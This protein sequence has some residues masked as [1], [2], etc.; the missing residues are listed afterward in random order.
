MVAFTSKRSQHML[1]VEM[2]VEII[3]RLE[4]SEW[5]FSS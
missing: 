2:Y 1:T 3:N 5:L 4:K